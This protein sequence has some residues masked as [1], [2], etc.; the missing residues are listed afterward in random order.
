MYLP[1]IQTRLHSRTGDTAV[2]KKTKTRHPALMELIHL[3]GNKE[4]NQ[5]PTCK[6]QRAISAIKRQSRLGR[7]SQ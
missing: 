4:N 7:E 1:H 6:G 2:E 3:Q 5:K